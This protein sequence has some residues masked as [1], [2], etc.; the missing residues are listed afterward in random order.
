MHRSSTVFL[1]FLSIAL[2][3]EMPEAIS[4]H[5]P[6][7]TTVVV[8]DEKMRH[9]INKKKT[10]RQGFMVIG[11]ELELS[12]RVK[13]G[14]CKMKLIVDNFGEIKSLEIEDHPG[15]LG[16]TV[17]YSSVIK[18]Y[19]GQNLHDFIDDERPKKVYAITGAT[20]SSQSIHHAITNVARQLKSRLFTPVAED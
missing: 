2:Q 16:H 5:F 8:S 12:S 9:P 13:S 6:T 20:S 17:K 1:L 11:W 19:A 15:P 10:I 7:A 14:Q 18:N 4:K 3:A